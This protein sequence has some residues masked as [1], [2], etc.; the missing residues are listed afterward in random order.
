MLAEQRGAEAVRCRGPQGAP[1][2]LGSRSVCIHPKC[3]R[4]ADGVPVPTN[5]TPRLGL[6]AEVPRRAGPPWLLT[7]RGGRWQ[8]PR[9]SDSLSLTAPHR[10]N[11]LRSSLSWPTAGRPHN[12]SC[13][14]PGV[15]LED[16]GT[17]PGSGK[18][19]PWGLSTVLS[20]APHP[21]PGD[22]CPPSCGL[23]PA[24]RAVLTELARSKL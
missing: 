17:I 15:A 24:T 23:P 9:L 12:S 13:L 22:A 21:A 7:G 20:S 18:F 14:T 4:G 5:N 2:F 19:L 1:G 10:H 16:V 11:V 6:I 8:T 3:P